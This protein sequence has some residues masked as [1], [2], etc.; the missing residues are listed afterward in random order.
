M[1]KSVLIQLLL[2]IL[3]FIICWALGN[4]GLDH[5]TNQL[6]YLMLPIVGFITAL[7][8]I[9]LNIIYLLRTKA[10]KE[11]RNINK[12]LRIISFV[13]MTLLCLS[14]I[15]DIYMSGVFA[16]YR[17]FGVDSNFF[18]VLIDSTQELG[19]VIP[20]LILIALMVVILKINR[21]IYSVGLSQSSI[22]N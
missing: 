11:I 21:K 16:Y 17:V 22:D 6:Y 12:F 14:A 13:I 2:T 15:L 20:Y 9:P 7:F 1:K 5:Y 10:K 8:L 18:R 3:V 19:F 4:W